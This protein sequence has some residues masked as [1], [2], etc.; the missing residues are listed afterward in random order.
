MRRWKMK[1][2]CILVK[3]ESYRRISDKA[4]ACSDWNGNE[5]VIPASQVYGREDDGLWIAEWILE[6]KT[7]NYS[8][9]RVAWFDESGRQLPTYTVTHH[10]PEG[11]KPRTGNEINE[12]KK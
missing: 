7:L 9:K 8:A 6:K 1:T 4:Y 12:L 10:T 2:K 5:A 3:L 11:V